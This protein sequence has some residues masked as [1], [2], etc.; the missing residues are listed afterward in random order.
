MI[1]GVSGNTGPSSILKLQA[2]IKAA[3]LW[4]AREG[5]NLLVAVLG[6]RD[7]IEIQDWFAAD[8]RQLA[9]IE[10]SNGLRLGNDALELAIA[11]QQS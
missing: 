7:R 6:S 11:T 4:L 3:D 1:N 9:A 5:N 2:G 8:Y 10:L